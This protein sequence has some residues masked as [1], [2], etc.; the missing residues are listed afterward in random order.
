MQN[1][2]IDFRL[3]QILEQIPYLKLLILFGSR[4]RGEHDA[5]SDWDLAV[6][7]DEEQRQ[8][9]E[10]GGWE[11]LRGWSIIQRELNLPDDGLDVVDLNQ[12]SKILAHSIARDGKLIYERESG[13]FEQFQ[14]L[15]LMTPI[16]LKTFRQER[17]SEVQAAL[18]E[19]GL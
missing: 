1:F 15:A 4:A 7:Y 11:W 8:E 9:Y 10:Q 13:T 6:L 2:S 17:R 18:Q 3:P 5:N 16:E 12:C 19:W 14:Q